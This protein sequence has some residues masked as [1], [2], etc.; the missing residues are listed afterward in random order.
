MRRIATPNEFFDILDQIK[1]GQWV[2]IGAVVGANLNGYPSVKRKNP[3]TNRMKGYPDH[4]AFGVP[5]EISALVK[6]SSYNMQ[7]SNR[8]RV[9]QRYGEWKQAVNSIRRDY[10]APEIQDKS[11]YKGLNDY[12]KGIEGYNGNKE[13]LKGHSYAPQNIFNVKPKSIV[14]AINQEGHIIQ[15]LK[16]EQVKPYIKQYKEYNSDATSYRD[17]GANALMK[18]GVEEEKIKE[19]LQKIADLKFSY[20]NFEANSILWIAASVNG[21]KI[22]Y[23]NNNLSRAVDDININPQ[24]FIAI[25]KERYQKDLNSLH[26][27]RMNKLKVLAEMDWRT[28]DSARNKAEELSSTPNIS[29]YE[30]ARR[31]NQ[32]DA[33]RKHANDMCDKQ[34]GIDKIKKREQD[35]YADVV[36][37]LRK[38]KFAYTN[39]DLK[40]FDRQLK[41]VQDYYNGKQ[42]YRDGKWG[43]KNES[44]NI[45]FRFTEND[46]KGFI[47]ES[48]K[49]ILS[50]KSVAINEGRPFKNNQGYS[51]FA[52]SKKSGK[53]I[54][55]WDYKGYDP[56]ELRQFK[57]DYFD[58]DLVDYGFNPKDFRILTFKYLVR[59][60][61]DPNDN[62]N[63]ANNDEANAEFVG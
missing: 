8:D 34:Y 44:K 21:E 18:M 52:V 12:G 47:R 38:D 55:G 35:H 46:L 33:F 49:R 15:A 59:N 1:G 32:A 61:I 31:K 60:G 27:M 2:T 48:I 16:P 28:Y 13:S 37:G 51:H 7:F 63:W 26:E 40:R 53:I 30:T 25:A 17:S 29:K 45:T 24:D 43:N 4:E 19:Y 10:G 57:K 9:S 50:K 41:D 11:G 36:H 42:E 20:M 22:V 6:I 54:N 5:E 62:S 14:Y 23:I 58:I 56:E 39:G 3:L